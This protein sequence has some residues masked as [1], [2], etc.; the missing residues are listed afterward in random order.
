M[1]PKL[2]LETTIPNYLTS[3]P[4]RDLIIASHQQ[5]T[6]EWWSHR[7]DKFDIYISQFVIDEARAGDAKAARDRLIAIRNFPLLDITPE[8]DDLATRIL[9]SG[10][11][12]QKAGTD[13]VHIAIASV[14][15]MQ[16][17]MTWNCVH[18]ANAIFAKRIERICRDYGHEILVICTPEELL[19][20]N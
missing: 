7:K 3:R 18:I 2:Y 9:A 10:I 14:H 19:G 12:P 5:I 8:V 6:K 20:E 17:L 4:S 11:I 13:A 15:Q 16:F 1:K